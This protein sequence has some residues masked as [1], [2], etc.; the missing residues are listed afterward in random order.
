M[1]RTAEAV[2][3]LG[4]LR[5]NLQQIKTRAPQSRLF[6]VIKANGYGHGIVRVAKAL[7]D[8]DGFGVASLAEALLLRKAGVEQPILL[9]EGCFTA[10]ELPIAAKNQCQLVIH[11]P[12]QLS[13]LEQADLE[14]PL[15]VWLKLDTGMHRLGLS[16]EQLLQFSQQLQTL[17]H[18]SEI[19]YMT[20]LACADDQHDQT[21]SRQLTLFQQA[22]HDLLGE[23][24]IANSAGIFG[25]PDSHADWLR[26]GISLYGSS[27]LQGVSAEQLG[28]K[29]VMSFRSRLMAIKQLKAGDSIGYGA[30]F[31]CDEDMLIGVISCG[32]GD[33]YPRHAN[34]GTPVLLNGRRV[35]LIGRVSMDMITVDLR[36]QP[37]A[38]IGDEVVLWGE[39]LSA[40]EVAENAAT[41]AYEL[42]CKITSRVNY[43][44]IDRG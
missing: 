28:L 11:Q 15:K 10:D 24:S 30:T 42:F 2:I 17:P 35:P 12:E 9:L 14:V 40:D 3:D 37:D 39:G 16:T 4:A 23:C 31:Q 26:P 33:G 32:Y 18:V 36:S 5:H 8:A 29:P 6:A 13:M 44:E 1:S 25:W 22:T 20:H 27:P 21:T 19:A 34:S 43:L 41:I 7:K 38:K